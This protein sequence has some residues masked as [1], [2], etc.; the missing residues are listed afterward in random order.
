M[1]DQILRVGGDDYV[2]PSVCGRG[3][4][5]GCVV[6]IPDQCPDPTACAEAVV[7]LEGHEDSSLDV[8]ED[9]ATTVIE[10][11]GA[12]RSVVADVVEVAQERVDRARPGPAGPVNGVS[13]PHHCSA[14][15]PAGELLFLGTLIH[16]RHRA[17]E[18]RATGRPCGSRGAAVIM[19]HR[20]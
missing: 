6:E 11:K 19:F 16:A 9:V 12:R 18:R 10:P 20:G 4:L 15:V 13:Y 2:L 17:T 5:G 8:L 7:G 1:D 14:N 3:E